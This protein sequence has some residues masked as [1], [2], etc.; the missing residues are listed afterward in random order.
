MKN[1][2]FNS[3]SA[4]SVEQIFTIGLFVLVIMFIAFVLRKFNRNGQLPFSLRAK[5]S[6]GFCEVE[7]QHLGNGEYVYQVTTKTQIHTVLNTKTGTV[8]LEQESLK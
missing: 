8:V 2:G 4:V 6:S 3:E 7:K 5:G 1:L